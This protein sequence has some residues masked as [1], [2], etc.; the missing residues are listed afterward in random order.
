MKWKT[1]SAMLALG[2][3]STF[4][5]AEPTLYGV[6]LGDSFEASKKALSFCDGCRVE[7][8]E[9][10]KTVSHY[11][12]YLN[13]Q[14]E[15]YSNTSNAGV[16]FNRPWEAVF[17]TISKQG[18]VVQVLNQIHTD[19]KTADGFIAKREQETGVPLV[20]INEGL[21]GLP[22]TTLI[23][24][25]R[26]R[27]YTL[28]DKDAKGKQYKISKVKARSGLYLV[29]VSYTDFDLYHDDVFTA[30]PQQ[31]PER[32]VGYLVAHY[33][34]SKPITMQFLPKLSTPHGLIEIKNNS[35]GPDSRVSQILLNGKV[36]HSDEYS[37]TDMAALP[38]LDDKYLLT[39]YT[40]GNSCS[41]TMNKILS[42]REDKT[43]VSQEFG[44]CGPPVMY[45]ATDFDSS[46]IMVFQSDSAEYDEKQIFL[47]R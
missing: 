47:M 24:G 38:G 7:F 5:Q 10:P 17:V 40:G 34:K 23:S 26:S 43:A 20:K 41:G 44:F 13:Y 15:Y 16:N 21:Q 2:L 22:A 12:V 3:F 36:I 29:S 32:E 14:K 4:S 6:K 31:V 8:N 46:Y 18:K 45:D 39:I 19:E 30:Q 9:R 37:I 25:S 1:W 11:T 27:T 28:D 35:G 33:S 42:I